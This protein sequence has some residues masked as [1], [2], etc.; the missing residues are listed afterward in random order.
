MT[1]EA[2]SVQDISHRLADQAEILCRELLPNGRKD[3]L[4]WRVGSVNGEAGNSLGV[5][6]VGDKAGIWG[7]FNGGEHKGDMLDLIQAVKGLDKGEAV[8]W[9]KARLGID[10]NPFSLPAPHAASVPAR[11]PVAWTPITPIPG[12]AGKTPPH[13]M[14]G[15]PSARW[16]YRDQN[17]GVSMIACRFEKPEGGKDVIPLTYCTN[18]DGRREWRWQSLP[19]PR[20]LYNL[21]QLAARPDVPV[22]MV[23]GE[24]TAVAASKLLTDYVVTTWPGGTGQTECFDPA[25]LKGR[26]VTCWPDADT[27][28]GG[29]AAMTRVAG[30]LVEAG[31]SETRIID[32]PDGLPN[33]W[34]LANEMPDGWTIETVQALIANAPAWTPPEDRGISNLSVLS[35]PQW[36][37]PRALPRELPETPVFPL[38][39][40]PA[41]LRPWI[42][43]A[44]DRAQVPAEFIAAPALVTLG[45]IVGRSVA[46]HPK[47][48]DDWLVIPNLWGMVIGRPGVLKS[49]AVNEALGPIKRLAGEAQH[50]HEEDSAQHE[51]RRM[52]A[53]ASLSASQEMAKAAAKSGDSEKLATAENDLIAANRDLEEAETHERRYFTNDGTVEKI[54]ELLNQNP[55]GLMVIRDELSGWMRNLEKS[56]R[57]GDRE[58]FLEAWNGTGRF[59]YDR[60]G[61]GTLHVDA[62]CLSML[63]TIQPG[64]LQSYITGAM[65]GGAGDDGLLQR[66]QVTVWPDITGE[67]KNVDRSPCA[68]ARERAFKVFQSLDNITGELVGA[69]EG[70][71]GV[72]ALRYAADAQELF[73][74]WRADLEARLRSPEMEKTPA[75]EAHLAKYRSL[76]PTIALLLHLADAV[77]GLASGPVSL[78]AAMRAAAWCDYLEAHARKVYAAEVVADVYRGHRL[79]DKIRA[80]VIQ[81]GDT[82]RDI[83]RHGWSGLTDTDDVWSGLQVLAQHDIARVEERATGGRTTEIITINPAIPRAA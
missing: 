30:R 51:A 40:L 80:G 44:S 62:L 57:E 65:A 33:K 47:A 55:R 23:E 32:L 18:A 4:E 64:K 29:I 10:N 28:G 69:I 9:A 35:V 14:H 22:I 37:V 67:W 54:G 48:H 39:L 24:K 79:M 27:D 68:A 7:D 52:M 12:D 38:D 53:K 63:G 81:D 3:G 72:P 45:G 71:D 41:S 19:A 58:F 17:G 75:F 59:T 43:D 5:R 2:I 66:F 36:G 8:H 50:A 31:V 11:A 78:D 46:I 16:A 13:P 61:R 60:I 70:F 21:G 77:D 20:P 42:N 82:L 34:D 6:L 76:Q 73:D 74:A 56:G 15:T 1:G 25:P 26:T 49:P 83:Y